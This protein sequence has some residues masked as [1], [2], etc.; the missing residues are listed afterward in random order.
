ME[1]RAWSYEEMPPCQETPEGAL[2]IPTT[3]EEVG[4][5]YLHDVEY[6]RPD[7]IPLTLQIIV[8]SQRNHPGRLYPGVVYVQGSAWMEQY[9]YAKV[10]YL[11]GLARRGCVVA[12]AQ[13]RHSG[14][15]RFPAQIQDAKNAIRF[16]R[17]NAERYSLDADNIFVGGDSSGGHTALFCGIVRDGDAMDRSLFPGVSSEVRGILS[18]YAASDLV[19]DDAFPTTLDHHTITSP[20]GMLMGVDLR[21]LPE[22]RARGTVSTYIT[23][24]LPMPPVCMFHGTKDRLVN[25]MA[26]VELYKTLRAAGKDARLYLVDGA[27]HGGPEFWTDEAID[28][29]MDFIRQCVT[30]T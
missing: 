20:E 5:E 16:M 8:P 9:V 23:P 4:L 28:I 22:F 19:H 7:G 30:G 3:G 18:Y 26:S 14:Q 2:R 24:E 15:A 21:E 11:G 27:D 17:R 29:A 25:T 10:P 6:I 12:I 13:Y 1:V